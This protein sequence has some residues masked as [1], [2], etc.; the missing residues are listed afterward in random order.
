MTSLSPKKLESA[1]EN[2]GNNVISLRQKLNGVMFK[3][4]EFGEWKITEIFNFYHE[5][6]E[7]LLELIF[8]IR[9]IIGA[10]K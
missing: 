7:E 2:L 9:L 10:L 4:N 3:T 6:L 5:F 8:A 1:L